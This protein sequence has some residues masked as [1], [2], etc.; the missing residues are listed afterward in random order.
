V[1]AHRWGQ[2]TG[3]GCDQFG[4]R[5]DRPAGFKDA[6]LNPAHVEQVRDEVGEAVSL[7]VNELG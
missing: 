6:R 5:G 4:E 2:V 3:H 7:D 1:S